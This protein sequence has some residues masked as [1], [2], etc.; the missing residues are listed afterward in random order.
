MDKEISSLFVCPVTFEQKRVINAYFNTKTL[1]EKAKNSAYYSFEAEIEA[2]GKFEMATRE[3]EKMTISQLAY[4]KAK[5][6][7]FTVDSETIVA[8]FGNLEFNGPAE[9]ILTTTFGDKIKI[10]NVTVTP[11]I[12]NEILNGEPTLAKIMQF[13]THVNSLLYNAHL[14]R[15]IKKKKTKEKKTVEIN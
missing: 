11:E 10:S 15:G 2:V 7:S 9:Y 14:R 13:K 3:L 1:L 8:Y 12:F 6:V 5:K 4:M